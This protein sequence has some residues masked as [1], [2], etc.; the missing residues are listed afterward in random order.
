MSDNYTNSFSNECWTWL[1]TINL[2]LYRHPKPLENWYL[3]MITTTMSVLA[4]VSL[5]GNICV[6]H[7]VAKIRLTSLKL[8]TFLSCLAASDLLT[9]MSILLFDLPFMWTH[10]F[11]W[12]L[13]ELGCMVAG[14]IQSF[15]VLANSSTLLA[16]ALDRHTAIVRS[17]ATRSPHVRTWSAVHTVVFVTW[18]VTTAI[19]ISVPYIF[20]FD[21]GGFVAFTYEAP[22]LEIFCFKIYNYCWSVGPDL[23]S[24]RHYQLIVM[25]NIFLPLLLAFLLCYCRLIHFLWVRSS[26]SA[27]SPA[28]SSVPSTQGASPESVRKKKRLVKILCCI[29]VVFVVCRLPAWLFLVIRAYDQQLAPGPLQYPENRRALSYT[30]HILQTL[31]LAATALNPFLFVLL[32]PMYSQYFSS[33]VAVHR[34]IVLALWRTPG[35]ISG[36]RHSFSVTPWAVT[37]S[38]GTITLVDIETNIAQE[39]IFVF[40]LTK[41]RHAPPSICH[42]GLPFFQLLQTSFKKGIHPPKPLPPARSI[43]RHS[44]PNPVAPVA[45]LLI[46]YIHTA[47]AD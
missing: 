17:M 4:V 34:R 21:Y 14:F 7:V 12:V 15:A 13:G 27:A 29:V 37:L 16:M 43:I 11:N 28:G 6:F 46:L 47:A 32:H 45:T 19:G 20:F 44:R 38:R 18:V 35:T 8:A 23:Q 3:Y 40:L 2:T 22:V 42:G 41:K 26:P 24:V 39:N 5:V 33:V 30:Q 9:V 31:T 36:S 1:K 25:L 10:D